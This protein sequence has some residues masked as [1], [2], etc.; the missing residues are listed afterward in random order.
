MGRLRNRAKKIGKARRTQVAG[1]S[2]NPSEFDKA[3]VAKGLNG[4]EQVYLKSS[5]GM[6]R[7]VIGATGEQVLPNTGFDV[8]MASEVS[9]NEAETQHTWLE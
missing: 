5:D 2:G 7:V 9:A 6:I 3:A 8:G 1:K 4:T